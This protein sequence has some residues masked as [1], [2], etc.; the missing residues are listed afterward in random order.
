MVFFMQLNFL[1]VSYLILASACDFVYTLELGKCYLIF[2]LNILI[3]IKKYDNEIMF[4][5]K[6]PATTNFH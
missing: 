5:G 1:D 2:F 6:I 4:V 3:S